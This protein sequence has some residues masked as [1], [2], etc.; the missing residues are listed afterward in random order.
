MQQI[1]SPPLLSA[2]QMPCVGAPPTIQP[3]VAYATS[4]AVMG[5]YPTATAPMQQVYPQPAVVPPNAMC[6]PGAMGTSPGQ[7]GAINLIV[8]TNTNPNG[9][10]PPSRAAAPP[11]RPAPRSCPKCRMGYITRGQARF[12]E[13]GLSCFIKTWLT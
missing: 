13:V 5:G 3:T 10:T 9:A 8:N 12:R 1:V 4:P 2:P 6:M 7:A 11:P